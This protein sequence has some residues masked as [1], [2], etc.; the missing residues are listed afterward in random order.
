MTNIPSAFPT[1]A[2]LQQQLPSAPSGGANS[3]NV[4][5]QGGVGG[6]PPA[7]QQSQVQQPVYQQPPAQQFPPAYQQ[8][9]AQ[10]F[11]P[12]YPQPPAQPPAAAPFNQPSTQQP[13]T[14]DP[15]IAKVEAEWG[16]P[17]GTFKTQQELTERLF[18]VIND[19]SP[20]I[21]EYEKWKHSQ[22]PPVQ[23]AAPVVQQTPAAAPPQDLTA[24][25]GMFQQSG[26][27]AQ[28]NGQWVAKN[29]LAAAVAEQM[30]KSVVEAQIRQ[31]EMANPQAW[32]AKYGSDVISQAV[33]PLQ[34][35]M[36]EMAKQNEMLQK[37][38]EDS[39]PR[40]DRDWVNQ[41]RN[42]LY[43]KDQSGQEVPTTVGNIYTTAWETAY[44]QGKRDY[45]QIHEYAMSVAAPL[46]NTQQRPPAQPQASWMSQVG[47]HQPDPSFNSPGTVFTNNVP[48]GQLGMPLANDGFPRFDLLRAYAQQP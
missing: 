16:I 47:Q 46:I 35:Q 30:N 7:N 41:N 13:P 12:A 44:R 31:M 48:N 24:V 10:Q 32:I 4:T 26:M 45:A 23:P 19:L 1:F 2:G 5:P 34:Q 6:W 38:L 40:P 22:A 14:V 21:D 29:P 36:A 11:P 18:E 25:A 20:K 17:V 27:L 28:E 39:V 9:P 15:Y 43:S 37:R 33:G 42:L 8:P 3:P